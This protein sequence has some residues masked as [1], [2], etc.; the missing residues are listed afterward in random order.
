MANTTVLTLT[1]WRGD[2][3]FSASLTKGIWISSSWIA[4]FQDGN[5]HFRPDIISIWWFITT[6]TKK[7]ISETFKVEELEIID[8]MSE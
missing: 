6:T 3:E 4:V 7:W 5:I 2:D 1:S 8:L